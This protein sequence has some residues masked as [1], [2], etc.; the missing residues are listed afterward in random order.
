VAA[1]AVIGLI[2]AVLAASPARSVARILVVP[3]DVTTVQQAVNTANPGDTIL[4]APGTYPGDV[5]VPSAKHDIMIRGASR[6]SVV[7]DGQDARA[8]A[9]EVAADRVRLENMTAHDFVANGFYWEDV[10]GY[11]GRYLTVWNVGAYGIYAVGSPGGTIQDSYVSGAADAAFYVGECQP[12]D[13]IVSHVTARFSAVGYSGTNAGG[14]L[15]ITDSLWDR[16]G[17]GLVPNSYDTGGQPPPQRAAVFRGNVVTGSGTAP[18]PV[19]S[20][21]GGLAGVGIAVAGGVGDVVEHNDVRNSSRYGIAVF[22]TVSGERTWSPAGTVVRENRITGSGIAD[23]ALAAG[24]GFGNCFQQNEFSLAD[25]GNVESAPCSPAAVAAGSEQVT[26]QLVVPTDVALD[27]LLAKGQPPS[28]SSMPKPSPQVEM[29]HALA[30]LSAARNWPAEVALGIAILGGLV[31]L[32][33]AAR[34]VRWRPLGLAAAGSA[35]VVVAVALLLM[36]GRSP[37]LYGA[38]EAAQVSGGGSVAPPT[39][40]ELGGRIVLASASS[41]G[42]Q[43][44]VRELSGSQRTLLTE[45]Q[46]QALRSPRWSP[47]GTKIAFTVTRFA[48][49]G[50]DVEVI[51]ADGTGLISLT[52]RPSLGECLSPSWS[53]DGRVGF[54]C[55][56]S[57]ANPEEFR[58]TPTLYLASADGAGIAKVATRSVS[59]PDW[60]PDGTKIVFQFPIDGNVAIFTMNAQGSA[61]TKL[62]PTTDNDLQPAWSPG[63]SEIA[64]TS[65]PPGADRST[66][67]VMNADGSNARVVVDLAGEATF[68]P[69]W[70]GPDLLLFT[71]GGPLGLGIGLARIGAAAVQRI[72]MSS[73]NGFD[74]HL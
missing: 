32:S 55:G 36:G 18:T 57:L 41:Q 25:P 28:Y 43:L 11:A 52:D 69:R 13:T 3:R 54:V 4:L 73:L 50:S 66:I 5:H 6:N 65:S 53:P 61:V 42:Q 15:L 2:G 7:F 64:F 70:A 39:F 34:R 22:A 56:R 44:V 68:A 40:G 29:P 8:N 17:A 63:G 10:K 38:H 45:P 48:S 9:I 71:F 67:V 59:L 33:L 37:N 1:A 72:A 16:N 60:S 46:D 21:L 49:L 19:S 14:N 12:C 58:G 31:G 47:D 62:T 51:N 24:G 23:L 20:Q 26:K 27:R 74:W 35:A 30:G